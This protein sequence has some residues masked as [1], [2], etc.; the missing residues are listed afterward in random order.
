MRGE[1]LLHGYLRDLLQTL[2]EWAPETRFCF[3][4][5]QH[6]SLHRF[7]ARSSPLDPPPPAPPTP[8]LPERPVSEKLDPPS[9]R[10]AAG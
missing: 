5:L 8:R 6:Q 3:V 7:G 1:S 10:H 4:A 2:N 9:K